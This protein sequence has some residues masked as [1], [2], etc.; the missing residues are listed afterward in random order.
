ML[1]AR[2][3]GQ[4]RAKVRKSSSKRDA[5]L[6]IAALCGVIS[7]ITGF[8]LLSLAVFRSPWFSWTGDYLSDL[9]TRG[10][11]AS[12]LFNSGLITGGILST[13]FAIGLRESPLLSSSPLGR[14]GAL[15]LILGSCAVW[16]IGVF[17]LETGA[18]HTY[19]ARAFFTL[20]PFSL[21]LI[22]AG[23][24]TS[25]EKGLGLF[26]LVMGVVTV[27]VALIPWPWDGGAIPQMLS[28][29]PL[30]AWSVVLGIGLLM[31]L[32]RD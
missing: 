11:D 16:A 29:L 30:S 8:A 20:I 1:R 2:S 21:L 27:V 22:G 9:G 14:L 5:S 12:M 10:D 32:K 7:P 15:A 25:A 3:K 23:M 19:A 6:R 31:R 28:V 13:L 17:P 24:M 4:E 18:T 26:T